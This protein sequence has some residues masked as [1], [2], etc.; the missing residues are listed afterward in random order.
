MEDE[1]MYVAQ[2]AFIE[3][4]GAI[5]IVDDPKEGLDFPG[6]KV[7]QGESDLAESLR[8]EVRE[9]CG[10]EIEI[11]APFITWISIL[12]PGHRNAGK[13]ICIIGYK[14]RYVSGEVALSEEHTGYRWVTRENY[15]SADDGTHYFKFLEAYFT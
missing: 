12:P 5:L 3:K 2:K 8:R 9:E 6:G 14:C 4:D 11:G 1:L 15:E 7:Q 13:K 10:L